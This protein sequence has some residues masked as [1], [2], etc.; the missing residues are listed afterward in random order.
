LP[1]P[2][3][4][5]EETA[6]PDA[7]GAVPEALPWHYLDRGTVL[8]DHGGTLEMRL[9]L[10]CNV[11]DEQ[12]LAPLRHEAQ[13]A[14]YTDMAGA[15]EARAASC[16]S[17][18]RYRSIVEQVAQL[19]HAQGIDDA[20]GRELDAKRSRLVLE[21]GPGLPKALAAVDAE[22]SA[23]TARQEERQRELVATAG[24]LRQ[25]RHDAEVEVQRTA[26]AVRAELARQAQADVEQR[27]AQLAAL[28]GPYLPALYHAHVR[29]RQLAVLA[30]PGF[31]LWPE[32]RAMLGVLPEL[33]PEPPKE[34]ADAPKQPPQRQAGSL[35]V[36][37][38][39]AGMAAASMQ[40][41]EVGG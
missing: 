13:Q 30:R 25:A 1:A 28:V 29:A 26:E 32:T 5:P 11:P 8:R 39:P 12:L 36:A 6:Q 31:G 33:P 18:Q 3:P 27:Q 7:P 22:R 10:A 16:E 35:D 21:A 37:P 40:H 23:L 15:L 24:A 34:P 19:R 17:Y 20:A 2:V 4:G 9:D 38:W 14:A 41:S